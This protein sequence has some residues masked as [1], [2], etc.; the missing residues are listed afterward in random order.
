MCHINIKFAN[1]HCIQL[2]DEKEA[3]IVKL[4]LIVVYTIYLLLN[5]Q[6]AEASSEATCDLSTWT[7]PEPLGLENWIDHAADGFA[8]GSGTREDPFLISTAEQL[9]YLARWVNAGAFEE[10]V[11]KN[12]IY[13]YYS[14]LTV[15]RV[16]EVE[17]MHFRIT[18]DIDLAGK[19]W[20]PIGTAQHPFI[21]IFNGGGN[22]ISNLTISAPQDRLGLFGFAAR[23]SLQ[24]ITLANVNIRGRDFVGGLVGVSAGRSFREGAIIGVHLTGAVEGRYFVGGLSGYA[25]I[26]GISSVTYLGSVKGDTYVGGL[27]GG[28]VTGL[29]AFDA[30]IPP[31]P[32]APSRVCA[33]WRETPL[34]V[35]L[36]VLANVNP[37]NVPFGW[38]V[39]HPPGSLGCGHNR[40][41]PVYR[42]DTY[43]ITGTVSARKHA[44]GVAGLISGTFIGIADGIFAGVINADVYR[45]VIGNPAL[46]G[47]F[48]NVTGEISPMSI[49]LAV[50]DNN[51][52]LLLTTNNDHGFTNFG[53]GTPRGTRATNNILRH[54]NNEWHLNATPLSA[55]DAENNIL[56]RLRLSYWLASFFLENVLERRLPQFRMLDVPYGIEIPRYEPLSIDIGEKG[57]QLVFTS[58]SRGE[59]WIEDNF[60]KMS[61]TMRDLLE[62]VYAP[63]VYRRVDGNF[64]AVDMPKGVYAVPIFRVVDGDIEALVILLN[65]V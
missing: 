3:K 49:D 60:F 38:H 4:V 53:Q 65:L 30:S 18:D 16:P 12:M 55:K 32:D 8:G 39:Q 34:S 56:R 2:G 28:L 31:I 22:V 58:F 59:F 37:F 43:S 19:E 54:K 25:L 1:L 63:Q 50:T 10:I 20:T 9:A 24:N 45:S 57:F 21:G 46:L 33:R 27:I 11:N 36:Y 51:I 23:S 7:A 44:G 5:T 47:P 40:W 41:G 62:G 42:V 15:E 6:A 48:S 26:H 61:G 35:P 14:A 13:L 17:A 29:T 64:V 52:V